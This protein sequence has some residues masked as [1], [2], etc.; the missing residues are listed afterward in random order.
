[1]RIAKFATVQSHVKGL[2]A[3]SR[4]PA[5]VPLFLQLICN[6]PLVCQEEQEAKDHLGRDIQPAIPSD[7]QDRRGAT[8]AGLM[9]EHLQPGVY[10]CCAAVTPTW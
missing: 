4:A 5:P 2:C 6:D 1:M 8:H 7:L 9:Q 3:W 10:S